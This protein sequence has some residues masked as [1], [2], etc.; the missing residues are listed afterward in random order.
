M[1]TK[2]FNLSND[3]YELT[4]LIDEPEHAAAQAALL[5]EI[6]VWKQKTDDVFPD[7]P[8]KAEKM[9]EV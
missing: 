5:A 2:L 4:N 3:P 8:F 9:Y 6:D 1:A 7:P